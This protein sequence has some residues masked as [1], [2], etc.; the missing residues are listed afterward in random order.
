MLQKCTR[1]DFCKDYSDKARALAEWAKMAKD[2]ALY[3]MA[4]R[5]NVRAN[6]RMGELLKQFDAAQGKRNDK[7][8]VAGDMKLTRTE[9][10]ARAGLSERQ[11][12]QA[13]RIANV[14]KVE[15]DR[16]I[17]SDNPPTVTALADRGKKKRPA[18]VG[19]TP[20][21][22]AST[23]L[24]GILARFADDID[25]L[26]WRAGIKASSD[27]LNKNN[28]RNAKKLARWLSAVVA[29]LEKKQ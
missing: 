10:A 6:E 4:L 20:E 21:K 29:A 1:V 26:E 16:L 25:S 12:N 19:P 5:I 9:A 3:K 13:L 15:R 2:E 24:H 17:E 18:H 22:R 7:P 27:A 14:P 11:K 28:L 23:R 8:H